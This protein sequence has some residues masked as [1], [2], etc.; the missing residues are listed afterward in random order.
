[1]TDGLAVSGDALAANVVL[2]GRVLRRAGLSA[3]ADQSPQFPD[4]A[5]GDYQ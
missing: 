3:D 1:M 4:D 2:F 5:L